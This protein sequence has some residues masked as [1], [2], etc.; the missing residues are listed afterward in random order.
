MV[1][2]SAIIGCGNIAGGYDRKVP[3]IWSLSH[4][5]AYHLCP[6]TE[7]IASA[8][9]KPESLK[10][11]GEKWGVTRLYENFREMLDNEEVDILSICLPTEKHYEIFKYACEK[12][13]PAIFCEKPLSNDL[14]EAVEMA[15]MSKGKIVSVNYFRRWN[16]SIAQLRNEIRN[17]EYGNVIQVTARYTKGVFV[18]G[19]HLV[20]LILWFFG[21][22]VDIRMIRNHNP[23]SVDPG[24]DFVL[25]YKNDLTTYFLN[26]QDA[27]YV[28][29]DID[30]TTEKGRIVLGQRGQHL[31]KYHIT[32]EQYYRKFS[33]LKQI[34]ETET[35]WRN[36]PTRAVREIVNCLKTGDQ[37]SCTPAD[38]LRVIE[39]CRKVV[40][41]AM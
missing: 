27:E 26:I 2:K 15:N 4:A 24:I 3:G 21:E 11:F 36:C 37:T 10:K 18:N 33:I 39:I 16:A 28:F 41:Q 23:A 40:S 25:N 6:D 20:D 19:S 13:V 32:S 17:G 7:L 30:I 29:V 14:S 1:L 34:E 22:P 9:V 35:D 31:V 38:G 8:D 5:G 12:N